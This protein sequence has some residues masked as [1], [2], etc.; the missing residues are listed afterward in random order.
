LAKDG[1]GL[2]Q[3]LTNEFIAKVEKYLEQ[4]EEEIMKV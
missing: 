3:D 4:K 1:E 2:V